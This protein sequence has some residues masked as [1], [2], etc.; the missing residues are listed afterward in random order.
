MPR[1]FTRPT[2]DR[3]LSEE[4]HAFGFD[5]SS[6]AQESVVRAIGARRWRTENAETIAAY[7]HITEAEGLPLTA[8]RKF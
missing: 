3:Q 6:T 8:F 4:E 7:N 5:V 2:L 1:C